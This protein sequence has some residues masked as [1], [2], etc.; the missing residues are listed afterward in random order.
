MPPKALIEVLKRHTDELMSLP[1]VVG[2]GQGLCGKKPCI[3]VF[4]VKRDP[5]LEK[6]IPQNL[7]GY[8]VSVEETGEFKMRRQ[9]KK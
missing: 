5:E 9:N 1:G 3:K 2:V 7:D 8:V 6:K 4:V